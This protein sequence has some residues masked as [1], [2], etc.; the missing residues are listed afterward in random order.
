[1]KINI[2][3][4]LSFLSFLFFYI[5]CDD[6]TTGID[7]KTIPDSNVSYAKD[8]A[9]VFEAKCNVSGCHD[10]ATRAGGVSLT[11]WVGTT[12]PTIVVKNNADQSILTYTI[13]RLSGVPAMP[14]EGYAALTVNQIN[15]IKIWI[16]E[17]AKNN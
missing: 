14:P 3:L 8:I 11:T 1:M 15:G 17:G 16:N 4:F 9:P 12:D 2:V 7:D 10:D 5:G 13:E 6:T